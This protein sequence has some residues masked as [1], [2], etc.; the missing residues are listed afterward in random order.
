[1][2]RRTAK[3][4]TMLQPK[5]LRTREFEC[6]IAEVIKTIDSFNDGELI[7]VHRGYA[8]DDVRFL[9]FPNVTIYEDGSAVVYT[10]GH[11]R[12]IKIDA[13]RI[14][15]VMKRFDDVYYDSSEETFK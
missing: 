9:S 14:K 5:Y 12:K 6:V 13:R 4:V 2:Q 8:V 1:M 3:E 7:S 10:N 11:G 15:K